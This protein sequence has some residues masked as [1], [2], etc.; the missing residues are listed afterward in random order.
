VADR[1]KNKEKGTES[2]SYN[3]LNPANDPK[4]L[5]FK[6]LYFELKQD[7]G[8]NF[9]KFFKAEED[10]LIPCSIFNKKL[11]SL[12]CIVKYLVENYGLRISFIAKLFG[13]TNKTV[14]QAYKDSLKKLPE[15]FTKVSSKYW[16]PA[17]I[18]ADR[19]ISVLEHISV[20][21]KSN[22]ELSFKNVAEIVCR[23]I[24]TVRTVYYRALKKKKND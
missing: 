4:F 10:Y 3:S 9:D 22:Y 13:R 23:D 21:L 12:E 16:I 14:W 2:S 8:K 1:V 20:Y 24:T 17:S 18:F 19:K 6:E 15:K 11:S 5:R 7:Y